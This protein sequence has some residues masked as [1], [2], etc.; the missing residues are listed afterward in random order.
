MIVSPVMIHFPQP[1]VSGVPA[2][3]RLRPLPVLGNFI[4]FINRL[5]E[6]VCD[7]LIFNPRGSIKSFQL[8]D[9]TSLTV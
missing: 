4:N 5:I 2:E 3:S 8:F 9:V 6:E 7:K 1:A